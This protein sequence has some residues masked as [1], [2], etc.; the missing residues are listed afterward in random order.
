M[1]DMTFGDADHHLARFSEALQVEA[2]GAA[3]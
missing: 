2:T 3:S 1:I